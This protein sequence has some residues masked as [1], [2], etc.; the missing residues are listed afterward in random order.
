MLQ[1]GCA[2]HRLARVES[3]TKAASAGYIAVPPV[4]SHLASCAVGEIGDT[5]S[6]RTRRPFEVFPGRLW[7]RS[8][9]RKR[10]GVDRRLRTYG[11]PGGTTTAVNRGAD[12]EGNGRDVRIW[13][14]SDRRTRTTCHGGTLVR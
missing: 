4:T 1:A 9:G 2:E 8:P 5:W 11:P 14:G 3:R 6:A 10:R 13:T 12:R 7:R